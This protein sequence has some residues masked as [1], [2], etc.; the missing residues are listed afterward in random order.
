MTEHL[1]TPAHPAH[2]AS[3][4]A[5]IM[6]AA[7]FGLTYSLSAALIAID[8][9]EM[10]LDEVLIGA[11][12]AMHAVGVLVMAF[13]LPR[14]VSFLGMRRAVVTG[15]V[16]SALLLLAFPAMPTFWLWFPLRVLLGAASEA[17]FVLSETWLNALS[18]EKTRAR[19]MGIYTAALSLGF[20]L[21]PM[22]LSFVGTDGAT[23]YIAGAGLAAFAALFILSPKVR[24]PVVE[25]PAHG[26][27]HQN[28][29]DRRHYANACAEK[30]RIAACLLISYYFYAINI[31]AYEIFS[32][33]PQPYE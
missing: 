4:A 26:K 10:G 12:A 8:L 6:A 22:I 15:L 20:A 21:G 25:K 33:T 19:A 18:S 3:R 27:T 7:V 30:N 1:A 9:A 14:L 16:S 11:N 2:I 29:R 23:P 24:A 31:V 13:L 17:L 5:V 32:D 28:E